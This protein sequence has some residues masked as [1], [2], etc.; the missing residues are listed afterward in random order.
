MS[1]QRKK[2]EI[3]H[4]RAKLEDAE[5]DIEESQAAQDVLIN[6]IVKL[7]RLIHSGSKSLD[8][9]IL[10]LRQ[11]VATT[12]D[13]L[14]L[15]ASLS[16]LTDI[17]VRQG[18]IK[19][20][21]EYI[22]GA[23]IRELLTQLQLPLPFSKS[24]H[25]FLSRLETVESEDDYDE[26]VTDIANFWKSNIDDV[27]AGESSER[28]KNQLC[29][30]LV[31][32]LLYQLLEK[33]DLPIELH[34][35]LHNLKQG[36]EEGVNLN[37]WQTTLEQV[38]E[39]SMLLSD[40]INSERRESEEFLN[41]T[42]KRLS[43]LELYLKTHANHRDQSKAETDDLNNNV[44]QE[45]GNIKTGVNGASTLDDIRVVI[46]NRLG[47]LEKYMSFF[48]DS[49]IERH[50]YSEGQVKALL[51]MLTEMERES[52][53]LRAKIAQERQQAFVDGLTGIANRSGYQERINQ[54]IARWKRFNAPLSIV[55]WDIDHFKKINDNYGHL[56]GDNALK[57]IAKIMRKKTRETDFIAR[58]GG[59]EFILVMPGAD[60]KS[61]AMVAEKLRKA[62]AAAAFH[63]HD[64]PVQITVS[65]GLA[66][67]VNGDSADSVFK[68]ADQALYAAKNAGRNQIKISTKS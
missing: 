36:M 31:S 50:K 40:K 20:P 52:N 63:F 22:A 9:A 26:L 27:K 54:E 14:L 51:H 3:D 16:K 49:E 2:T 12:P 55:V 29:A 45:L 41:Q 21:S 44:L 1:D 38:T 13:K 57:S 62:V 64:Q 61:G 5:R 18:T 39:I 43:E 46:E 4:W 35:R 15:E 42:T 66:E 56:A 32:E 23:E 17:V 6:V 30:L 19:P 11:I 68:R 8:D 34:D 58:F 10:G 33:I 7:S 37:E 65:G 24:I 60:A 48:R 25:S 67:F 47:K 53:R 28:N 59:E